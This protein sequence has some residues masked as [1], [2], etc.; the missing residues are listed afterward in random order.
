MMEL[1]NGYQVSQA[2]HV[3][4]TLGI[5][6]LLRNGPLDSDTLASSAGV[7]RD[8]LYRLLRALAAVGVLHEDAEQVFSL[9]ELGTCLRSDAPEPVGPWA[10]YVG[11]PY[12]WQVWSHLLYSVRTGKYAFPHVH[13]VSNWEY[14]IEHPDEN[15][16]FDAAMTGNTRG[17]TQ[18]IVASYDFSPCKRIV[19]VGG[20]QGQLI[21][22]VLAANEHLHGALI[23]QPQVVAKADRL[24]HGMGVGGRCEIRGG[25]FFAGVPAGDLHMMKVVLHDWSDEQ[26]LAILRN[27]RAATTPGGR[28]L[29]IE[30]IIGMPNVGAAE[31]FADLNMMVA[32]GGRERT[33]QEFVDLFAIAGYALR[34]VLPTGTHLQLIEGTCM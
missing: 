2:L 7:N 12:Y 16:I 29:V 20:G 31:K 11:R 1:I 34:R 8:A 18:A 13:G 5:A 19:D 24:L 6:D 30:R 10:A 17:L 21:G 23:D 14:R 25:D 9:T 28:L 4:A 33:L 26:A 3:A 27:C 15:A 32:A 22:S